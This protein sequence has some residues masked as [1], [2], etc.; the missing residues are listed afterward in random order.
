M[1]KIDSII[2][3]VLLVSYILVD[4]SILD[5]VFS[6]ILFAFLFLKNMQV[7]YQ[8]L[9]L[10]ETTDFILSSIFEGFKILNEMDNEV[11]KIRRD[12]D[13]YD[14]ILQSMWINETKTKNELKE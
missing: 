4:N 9:K 6:G 3:S 14:S 5:K 2:F 11:R 10:Q 12:I 13:G 7:Y 8:N 1:S